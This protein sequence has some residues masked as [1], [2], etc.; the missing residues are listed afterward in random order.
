M[1]NKGRA[2]DEK[3]HESGVRRARVKAFP[4]HPV[5]STESANESGPS[6][7]TSST[8]TLESGPRRLYTSPSG[9]GR[10]TVVKAGKPDR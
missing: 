7:S 10:H 9:Q 2:E 3:E 8:S 1:P 5:P 4:R 6:G